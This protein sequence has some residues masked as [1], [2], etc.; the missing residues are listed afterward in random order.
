MKRLL[1][2]FTFFIVAQWAMAQTQPEATLN[3]SLQELVSHSQLFGTTVYG[4]L[5]YINWGLIDE[6]RPYYFGANVQ[7][8]GSDTLRNLHLDIEILDAQTLNTIQ[9]IKTDSADL[10]P[11]AQLG[12]SVL[13]TYPNA[14]QPNP[15]AYLAVFKLVDSS[16]FLYGDTIPIA[17]T[18][19]EM[20]LGFGKNDN[21]FP[22]TA[23]GHDG[24]SIAVR[25]DINGKNNYVPEVIIYLESGTVPGGIIE[26][27]IWDTTGFDFQNGFPQSSLKGASTSYMITAADT[28]QGFVSL[29][30]Q[31][32]NSQW[33]KLNSG[34]YFLNVVLYTNTGTHPIHIAN[35]QSIEQHW[36]SSI[37]FDVNAQQWL[38]GI[39]GSQNLNAPHLSLILAIGCNI[40]EVNLNRFITVSPNPASNYFVISVTDLKENLTY[41]LLDITGR[42]I[43]SGLFNS[44]EQKIMRIPVDFLPRGLY[45]VR[46][47][48]QQSVAVHKLVLQ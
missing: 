18:G 15:A 7:N 42:E 36:F 29:S 41:Q 43:L 3:A 35:D 20:T 23:I 5:P 38:S 8:T 21:I 22:L 11:Q 25:F 47:M 17:V 24:G 12:S 34:S 39:S 26:A 16:S 13:T 31:D 40:P 28:S 45:T 4:K 33:P 6:R 44:P 46:I 37:M 19:G 9:I 14:F 1:N 48:G 2:I 27:E 32:I 30:M 10:A